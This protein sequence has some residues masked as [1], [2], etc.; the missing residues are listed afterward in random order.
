M[1]YYQTQQSVCS[2]CGSSN[3][4]QFNQKDVYGIRCLNCGHEKITLD[5]RD[6]ESNNIS[7]T[8]DRTISYF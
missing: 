6:K 1:Y 5:A 8:N 4:E 2:K 7:Y 3:S